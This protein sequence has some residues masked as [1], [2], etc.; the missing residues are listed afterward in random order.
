M[1]GARTLPTVRSTP[2]PGLPTAWVT[3]SSPKQATLPS[4]RSQTTSALRGLRIA[5]RVCV[6]ISDRDFWHTGPANG[7]GMQK[8]VPLASLSIA[9]LHGK[10]ADL[11][12][13]AETARTQDTRDALL[14]LA[15][16]YHQ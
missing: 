12:K 13:M 9:D 1:P 5:D 2:A 6:N 8:T 16:R 14:R 7:G 10:A 15:A 11:R 3:R 4:I